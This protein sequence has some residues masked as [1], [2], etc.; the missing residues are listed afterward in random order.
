MIE[1]Q[2]YS[3]ASIN[4]S[5]TVGDPYL[6]HANQLVGQY[7]EDYNTI[8]A[9]IVL[10]AESIFKTTSGAADHSY[11][12]SF[13]LPALGISW[14]A[15]GASYKSSLSLRVEIDTP[16]Q[17]MLNTGTYWLLPGDIRIYQDGSLA[18]TYSGSAISSGVVP[19]P[20]A[21][22]LWGAGFLLNPDGGADRRNVPASPPRP[23]NW[24][25]EE[26]S[27]AGGGW[28]V[29]KD[30]VAY[31]F[32][33]TLPSVTSAANPGFPWG[34]SY[35]DTPSGSDTW[36]VHVSQHNTYNAQGVAGVGIYEQIESGTGAIIIVPDLTKS[37]VRMN[38]DYGAMV[39]RGKFPG[40]KSQSSRGGS[41]PNSG[42]PNP[43]YFPQYN[44]TQVFAA[45]SEFLA[46]VRNGTHAIEDVFSKPT[47]CPISTTAF[48]GHVDPTLASHGHPPNPSERIQFEFPSQ[49]DGS[50]SAPASLSYLTHALPLVRYL[51]TWANPHWSFVYW[52]PRDG[53][54]D[55]IG[56]KVDGGVADPPDYWHPLKQQFLYH[57]NLPISESPR[58]RNHQVSAAGDQ[59]GLAG[60]MRDQVFGQITSW[61]GISRFEAQD[62]G[63]VSPATVD[64]TSSAA[65]SG[66]DC[67]I[68]LES[69]RVRLNSTSGTS[70]RA[71]Y[72]VGLDVF[73]RWLA[74]LAREIEVG[75]DSTNIASV[76]VSLRYVD[77]S[78]ETL[79]TSPGTY[80]KPGKVSS[81]YAGSWGQ[82]FGVDYTSDTG[83]DADLTNG[84]SAGEMGYPATAFAFQLPR[85]RTIEKLRFDVVL[86][87]AS[88]PGRLTYPSFHAATEQPLAIPETSQS[89][90]IV[91][92][93]GPMVR[94][95]QNGFWD[96]FA[97]AF[98]ASPTLLPIGFTPTALDALCWRRLVFEG[99]APADGLDTEIGAIYD[100]NET[101]GVRAELARDPDGAID[102]HS[103][104][105]QGA[106]R[107]TLC[108]VNSYREVPPLAMFP[109]PKRDANFR[110]VVGYDQRAY[111]FDS[112]EFPLISDNHGET[113]LC[114]PDGTQVSIN[115]AALP[116]WQK[117]TYQ[118]ATDGSEPETWLIRRNAHDYGKVRPYHG[119][120]CV[121]DMAP[122]PS[123][124]IYS[125]QTPDGRYLVALIDS[126][127]VRFRRAKHD[128]P[129]GN[130]WASDEVVTSYGDVRHAVFAVDLTNQRTVMLIIRENSGTFEVWRGHSDDF[131]TTFG[132]WEYVADARHVHTGAGAEGSLCDVWFV[133][134]S[135]SSGPG[136]LHAQYRGPG[137]TAYSAPYLIKDDTG[138]NLKPAEANAWSNPVQAMD[139]Q[140]R[141]MLTMTID[142]DTDPSTWFSTDNPPTTFKRV[143]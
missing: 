97:D 132:G 29:W 43:A 9:G 15:S 142:G 19:F 140:A 14:A 122:T 143:S 131:G 33:I 126:D 63:I 61:W 139:G 26:S 34:L 41:Q 1:L 7:C 37:V 92:T 128:V 69:T 50:L 98:S 91:T 79:A 48:K 141:W 5:G 51:N 130:V 30:G 120:S 60:L 21:A 18:H 45:E 137:D 109:G 75:W 117:A 135:G 32:P 35:T 123:G 116:G 129:I 52:Y 28:R 96:Y 64:N 70:I 31:A 136:T 20:C 113:A 118:T 105:V 95:G 8:S 112:T 87:D 107:P 108:I 100:V 6:R 72:H 47:Y 36:N 67:T 22:P 110:K 11:A 78:I 68:T 85:S 40:V 81:H 83:I 74:Q 58:Y 49:V 44:T 90:A 2:I 102:T 57:P 84:I 125:G 55:S 16:K 76:T 62:F 73:P 121:L 59:N 24:V 115:G 124:G 88:Q 38:R 80:A 133:Y 39:Y 13:V 114:K 54:P 27:S 106:T 104:M 42:P 3:D 46:T 103:F 89:S 138:A 82:D 99:K 134:D 86:S 12:Y 25:C 111:A 127:D 17:Y 94:Y 71:E 66:T 65:W 23:W 77:G 119:W 101:A 56:W 53:A 10:S 93:N 4:Q